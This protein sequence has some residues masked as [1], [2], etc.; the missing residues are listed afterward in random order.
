MVLLKHRDHEVFEHRLD[1]LRLGHVGRLL[2]EAFETYTHEDLQELEADQL[3]FWVVALF[4][5]VLMHAGCGSIGRDERQID[6]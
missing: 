4:S 6:I 2:V 5:V 1:C 3:A